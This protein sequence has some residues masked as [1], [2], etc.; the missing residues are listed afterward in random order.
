MNSDKCNLLI[1]NHDEGI[2]AKIGD[3]VI[4]V[5]KSV[6]LLGIT[7][8]NKLNFNEHIS[9]LCKKV[10]LKLHALARISN[11]MSS[12]KLRLIMKAFIESQFGYCPLVWMNHSRALNNKINRLHKRALR[13]VYKDNTLSF[14]E[15]LLKDN[16]VSIHHRN[17][18]KL[19]TEMYK[20]INNH[21]PTIMKSIF[22]LS[23][24]PYELRNKNPFQTTNVHSVYNG[25]ETISFRGPKIW[26]LVPDEIKKSKCLSEFK[27][28]I[29][30]WI[31]SGCVC[32]LCKEYI[33][34]LGFI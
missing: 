1:T 21:S 9:K 34:N 22:Q 11:Y 3:E 17:L 8:D 6:K 20:I 15:L 25:T 23:N 28:K 26:A 32:R 18:Q 14:D 30:K 33:A 10:S 7:I 2:Q 19:A 29:K 31:P 5:R 16:S 24:N 13:L 12:E 27:D 4:I